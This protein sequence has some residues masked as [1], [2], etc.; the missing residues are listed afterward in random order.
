MTFSNRRQKY[1]K[2][3][4]KKTLHSSL[5][6]CKR[7]WHSLSPF[8]LT[9]QKSNAAVAC[10]ETYRRDRWQYFLLYHQR[11]VG[12]ASAMHFTITV[13]LIFF[14]V[15]TKTRHREGKAGSSLVAGACTNWPSVIYF[16]WNCSPNLTIWR[17]LFITIRVNLTLLP[18]WVR[19]WQLDIFLT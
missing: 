8:P 18:S 9:A 19:L 14:P 5:R 4:L 10:W 6:N 3:F 1:P 15:Q 7:L 11:F 12:K 16:L 17:N 2:P 13:L